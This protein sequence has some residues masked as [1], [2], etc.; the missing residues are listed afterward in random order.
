MT[1]SLNEKVQRIWEEDPAGNGISP[2]HASL[3]ILS[4]IY[5]AAISTRNHL[6]DRGLL[7]QKRLA[8]PV[9]SVGNLTVG[10]TGKTPTVILLANLLR[11]RGRRPAVLSRGYGGRTGAPVNIVSDGNRLLMG[12]PE[13]GDEP[14]LIARAAPGVPVLTGSE[15]FLTGKR[16]LEAFGAD[17]L[18]LDDAFQ[19]RSLHRD[20]D[21]LLIDRTRPFGNGHLL[22]RGPLREPPEALQRA[23][24]FIRTGNGNEPECLIPLLPD[25]PSFPG[26]RRPL[27]IIEGGTG[28]LL[29]V[30]SLR[31]KR[32]CAFAGIGRPENFRKSLEGLGME[33]VSFQIFPDHHPYHRAELDALCRIASETGADRIVTTEKDGIRLTSFP[34]FLAMTS[35]LRIG[36]EITPYRPFSELIFSSLTY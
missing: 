35:L 33:V 13:A 8:C 20:L 19:H 16:A 10:G 12:W 25:R 34:D 4:S 32:V 29:P 21:I 27:G 31:G 9:F 7:R 2:L 6:F 36:M 24:L 28:P 17:S 3:K 1:I 23:H 22:P 11:E 5:H 15:R 26:F 18:I 14:L 30:E